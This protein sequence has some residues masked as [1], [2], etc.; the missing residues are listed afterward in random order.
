MEKLYLTNERLLRPVA[1]TRSTW[2]YALPLMVIGATAAL[3]YHKVQF[4]FLK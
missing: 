3:V 4:D 1:V 2:S